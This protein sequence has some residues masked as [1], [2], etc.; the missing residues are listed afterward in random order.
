MYMLQDE[1][2]CRNVKLA[3]MMVSHTVG[4]RILRK[5]ITFIPYFLFL[6]IG[7]WKSIADPFSRWYFFSFFSRIT[8]KITELPKYG[9]ESS[10]AVLFKKKTILL[11]SAIEIAAFYGCLKIYFD[12]KFVQLYFLFTI[13]WK[14]IYFSSLS[15]IFPKSKKI[16]RLHWY[17]HFTK[18]NINI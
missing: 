5:N 1:I 13:N 17:F 4:F 8:Q 2:N 11:F 12:L 18:K 7:I 14:F 15:D 9:A 16:K 6:S 3:T 10:V